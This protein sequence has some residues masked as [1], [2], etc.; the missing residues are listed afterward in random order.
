M[1][2]KELTKPIS[3]FRVLSVIMTYALGAGLVQYV[4]SI[5][6]WSTFIQG[7]VFIL[8]IVLALDYLGALGKS[9]NRR[10][11]PESATFREIKQVRLAL[12][13]ISATFMTVA[14]TL[15]INWIVS[16]FVWQ[17]LIVLLIAVILI[18]GLYYFS[19]I[20]ERL[21]PYSILFEAL[22]VVVI[23]PAL[24][25]FIQSAS[26]HQLLTLVILGLVPIYMAYSLL[27]HLIHYGQEEKYKVK[28]VATTLG[29][30]KT[31]VLHN[32]L[33]LMGY[34]LMALTALLGF[35]W[36]LLW[37]IFLT[38]PIALLEIWL[39]ERVRRGRKP[40]WRIMQFATASVFFI[41]VYLLGFAFW[42]R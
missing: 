31:M 18:G 6:S 15:F 17:G 1:N 30:E 27:T 5:R 42:I 29:W 41:P 7:G 4:E 33:I 22:L 40:L 38:F 39:M 8:L 21:R 9:F 16:G 20:S 14:T 24:G 11:W 2:F 25:Y 28:T 3:I 13:L 36:F 32:A 12:G 35:P 26:L 10:T 37:P 19:Q 23:P 34:V